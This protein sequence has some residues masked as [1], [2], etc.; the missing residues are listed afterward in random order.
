[1]VLI[2]RTSTHLLP[3]VILKCA[4]EPTMNIVMDVCAR[5]AAPGLILGPGPGKRQLSECVREDRRN[6]G[7]EVQSNGGTWDFNMRKEWS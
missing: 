6:D 1:M 5:F 7:T 3:C 4:A 2:G